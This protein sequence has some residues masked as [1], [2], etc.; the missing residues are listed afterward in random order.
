MNLVFDR[1]EQDVADAKAIIK[2]ILLNGWDSLSSSQKAT[3]LNGLK[4]AY[5]YTDLNR[6]ENAISSVSQA[7]NTYG[8]INKVNSKLDWGY[9][10]LPTTKDMARIKEN[11]DNL[12]DAYYTY[13]STP[14]T[15]AEGNLRFLDY[16]S[17]NNLEKILYDVEEIAY[18][19]VY[20]YRYSNTFYSNLGGLR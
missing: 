13:N 9:A 1:T 12:R 16:V 7:L 14:P 10:A 6:L 17:A 15:P 5:N 11:I 8:Y 20:S 3:Y 18:K 4:G 19:M 2:L